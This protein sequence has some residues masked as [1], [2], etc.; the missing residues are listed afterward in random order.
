MENV[1][2]LDIASAFATGRMKARTR[3]T[4]LVAQSG[5]AQYPVIEISQDGLVIEAETTPHL[6][7]FLDICMGDDLVG[8]HL[9][10][11][12]WARDG[13]VGYEFKRCEIDAEVPADYEKPEHAGLLERPAH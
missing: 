6:H 1:L 9:V 2:P 3:R 8:R 11:L 4:G 12:A 10:V 13:L 7:G 5:E